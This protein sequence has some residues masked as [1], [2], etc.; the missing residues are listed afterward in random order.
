MTINF[1]ELQNHDLLSQLEIEEALIKADSNSW[2][3][4]N[5]GSPRYIVMGIS[6][7]PSDLLNLS[8]V[9]NDKIKIIKRFSGGGTVIVDEDSIFVSFIFSKRILPFSFPEEIYKWTDLFYKEVFETPNFSRK[10]NDYVLLNKKCC[11]NAQYIRKNRWLHHST[12]LWN[13]KT[14]NMDY[15]KIPRISPAYRENRDHKDFLTSISS[16][17]PSKK[18]F[19]EKIKM[20]LMKNF[21]LNETSLAEA[22]KL[23]EK[24]FN[25]S[26]KIL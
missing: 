19:I 24:K 8:K 1:L 23:L 7:N 14:G 20:Q 21:E 9:E 5:V 15:L 13:F 6:N 11:G 16:Y 2:C 12:F 25:K 22:E 3:I 10:E 4:V 26:T 18:R 17:F